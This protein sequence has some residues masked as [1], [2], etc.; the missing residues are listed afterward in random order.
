MFMDSRFQAIVDFNR[1]VFKLTAED[2]PINRLESG[3]GQHQGVVERKEF[4][5]LAVQACSVSTT[6]AKSGTRCSLL[7][8][9]N[10]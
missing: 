9:K 4:L 10:C 5:Q 6:G 3:M 2:A 1:S 7:F 8:Q